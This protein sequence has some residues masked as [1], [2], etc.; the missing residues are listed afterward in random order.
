MLITR[1]TILATAPVAAAM[2]GSAMAQAPAT[3]P[4][5]TEGRQMPGFYRYK[6]GDFEVTAFHDGTAA[7]PLD[8][9]FVRNAPLGEVQAA[10]ERAFLPKDKLNITFTTLV[11]NTGKN[12]VAIDTGFADNGGPTTGGMYANLPAAGIDPKRIDTVIISHFHPDHILGVRL[13]DGTAAYPNAQVMVPAP[14]WRFW[15]D[16]ARMSQAPEAMKPNFQIVRRAFGPMG[17]KVAQYEWGK[18][19]VPGITTVE[20]PGHTPG[21]TAFV[22]ASGNGRLMAVSD[23]TNHPALFVRNPDWSAVFDMD[24]DQA[25]ATRRRMLDMAASERIQVAFYHAPFPATGHIVK[26]GN[27][28]ELVPV[29]WGL[30]L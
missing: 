16:D 17:D 8:D 29:Q 30:N 21:H 9:K 24:A 14:E 19:I 1:R 2:S 4:P 10:L 26:A 27:G 15:M 5:V 28:F 13:K 7:R 20:A 6:V 25:R 23:I 3:T 22:I 18:E 11:I 12:L